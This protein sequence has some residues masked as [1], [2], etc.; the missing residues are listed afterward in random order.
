MFFFNLL[1]TN[2]HLIETV[3]HTWAV[4]NSLDAIWRVTGSPF[5]DIIFS[6]L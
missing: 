4:R 1:G 6:R 2:V 5:Y 3:L